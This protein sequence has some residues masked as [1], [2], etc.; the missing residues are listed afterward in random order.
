[1]K[2]KLFRAT[3]A[4]AIATLM[5]ASF[6]MSGKVQ[7]DGSMVSTLESVSADAGAGCEG[8]GVCVL[9]GNVYA[10]APVN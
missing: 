10:Y 4:L 6:A 9:Q 5:V 8:Q 7:S 2:R 1:M 3:A